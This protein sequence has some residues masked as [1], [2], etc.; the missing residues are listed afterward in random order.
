MGT[1]SRCRQWL[2]C[3]IGPSRFTSIA[4]VR[5]CVYVRTYIY[6]TTVCVC[7]CVCVCVCLCVCVCVCVCTCACAC[8]CVCMLVSKCECVCVQVCVCVCVCVCVYAYVRG[9]TDRRACVC[10]SVHVCVLCVLCVGTCTCVHICVSTYGRRQKKFPIYRLYNGT[11][12]SVPFPFRS[13]LISVW[14]PFLSV[15]KPFPFCPKGS[16]SVLVNGPYGVIKH[17]QSLIALA[18]SRHSVI[19]T[20]LE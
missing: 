19:M 14:L 2:K 5:V 3:T 1:T 15:F 13:R 10:A 8:V 18:G 9:W 17:A 20:D 16:P 4:L 12:N 7:L 6:T 11:G